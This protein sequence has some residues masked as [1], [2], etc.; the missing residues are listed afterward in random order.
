[1][2]AQP[3]NSV[4]HL[5]RRRAVGWEDVVIGPESVR[6]IRWEIEGESRTETIV[7]GGEGLPLRAHLRGIEHRAPGLGLVRE[8][9]DLE[10]S[11][12]GAKTALHLLAE[13]DP[14]VS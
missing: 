10:I 12:G 6:A 9:A 4:S 14:D 8:E 7:V 11:V 5:A 13:R 3:L 2:V 1:M